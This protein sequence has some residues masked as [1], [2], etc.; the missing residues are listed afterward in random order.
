[1]K[2]DNLSNQPKLLKWKFI[3]I[4]VVCLIPISLFVI[5]HFNKKTINDKP[6]APINSIISDQNAGSSP[7]QTA[8][9]NTRSDGGDRKNT[10]V[11]KA[12]GPKIAYLTFDDGPSSSVTPRILDIL[13]KYKI[14]ATF[15][16]I[17]QHAEANK[18][19][20][21]REW[22]S[23]DMV[24][25]HTFDHNVDFIYKDPKNLVGEFNEG[26]AVLKSII[27]GYNRKL[28]RFPGGSKNRPAIFKKDVIKAGYKYVDWNCLT[29]DAE[30]PNISVNQ[31]L[32]YIKLFSKNKNNL[33][34][35]MHDSD[36]RSTTADALPQIIDYL[37]SNDY[38]FKTLN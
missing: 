18:D 20:V 16:L 3:V 38:T 37:K 30:V 8:I 31:Q 22:S 7:G 35:L 6:S 10:N 11:P 12:G 5:L 33:I 9:K 19:L 14:K 1:M 4:I 27:Q 32:S 34:V 29:R 28:C 26:D 36:G 21:E 23:G 13:D 2:S 24:G 25:N 17:G 15:F